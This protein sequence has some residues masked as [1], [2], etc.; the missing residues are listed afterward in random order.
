MGQLFDKLAKDAAADLPRRQAFRVVG[1]ALL[2]VVLA[3]V[4][5]KADSDSCGR[6][7]AACCKTLDFPPRSREHSECMRDCLAGAG[8]CGPIA[9]P[10]G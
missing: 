9:C 8:P 1:G 5:L 2:G 10:Q 4:G 6:L 3:A 7:C